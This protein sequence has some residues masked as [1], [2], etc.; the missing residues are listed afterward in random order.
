[1]ASPQPDIV[2]YDL[3]SQKNDCF[4]PV[5]WRIR[6]MLNYKGIP[7]TTIFLEF[8][9][10]EPTLKEL[11]LDPGES[12]PGVKNKYTV[13]AI[14]HIPSNTY[15]LESSR[16][17]EF[18]ETTYPTPPLPLHSELGQIVE[19]ASRKTYLVLA[20]SIIPREINILSPRSQAFFRK[21][22]EAAFGKPLEELMHEDEDQSW[23]AIDGQLQA[24]SDLIQTN[25]ADGPFIL[26]A[27]PS[28]SDFFLAG[29]LQS[30]RMIDESVFQR[31]VKYPGFRGVYEACLPY[32]EIN[33][34]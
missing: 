2:L 24:A 26:G 21:T 5:V 29:S 22:R 17:A 8:P 13:P 31:L 23:A 12:S 11:G 19:A 10:I 30:A 33:R 6:L 16:I 20:C 1:M 28:Y 27:K 14:R 32:G 7:Y 9:D 3:A 25:K 34:T 4:S 18:I 15:M